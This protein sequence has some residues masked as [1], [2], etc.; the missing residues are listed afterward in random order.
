MVA[1][2]TRRIT[3]YNVC[4][5]K[6][7]RAASLNEKD[8]GQH[9][10]VKGALERLLPMCSSMATPGGPE[11][12]DRS[13]LESQAQTL[14]SQGYRVMALADGG[15][16]LGPGEVFSGEHLRNLTLIGLVGLIDPL[17]PE[18]KAAITACRAAGIRVAML[19]YNFV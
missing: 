14:A 15:I 2:E 5:T 12:L 11:T 7:L 8:G 17:R 6:L 10:Y 4:Y 13:A 9:A 1:A 16:E 3:S 19:S 18:A